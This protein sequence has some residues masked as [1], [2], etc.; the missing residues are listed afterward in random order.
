MIDPD[1]VY[2]VYPLN[3]LK[4]H[5][6]ECSDKETV[7]LANELMPLCKCECLPEH[8]TENGESLI[9]VHNSFDGREGV[10]WTNEVLKLPTCYKTGGICNFNCGGLCK[11]SC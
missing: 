6:L 9:I 8:K 4:E 1:K 2:H 11:N 10:E 7:F 3:D 5:T